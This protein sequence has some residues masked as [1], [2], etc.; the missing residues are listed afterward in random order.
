MRSV[1][2]VQK[3]KK[4]EKKKTPPG[5]EPRGQVF[6]WD[7]PRRSPLFAAVEIP[8]PEVP[9]RSRAKGASLG[10]GRWVLGVSR[11]ARIFVLCLRPLPPVHGPTWVV[12]VSDLC[13]VTQLEPPSQGSTADSTCGQNSCAS[14]VA[15]VSQSWWRVDTFGGQRQHHENHGS[16]TQTGCS[17]GVL[18]E[19]GCE[20]M[21]EEMPRYKR[22][23]SSLGPF[24]LTLSQCK[25]VASVPLLMRHQPR[26][27]GRV[28]V[29]AESE[30]TAS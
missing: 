17:L 26:R 12:V 15:I 25:P 29:P 6:K 28:R 3:R 16:S 8:R 5:T 23:T 13:S 18:Q 7:H 27:S 9:V 11:N 4:K 20:R 10:A 30:T 21:T 2:S 19:S 1:A 24:K 22:L 14:F